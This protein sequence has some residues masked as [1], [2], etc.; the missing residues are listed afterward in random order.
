MCN[1]PLLAWTLESLAQAGVEQ[2]FLFSSD[3]ADAIR[4]YV[5]QTT[6]DKPYSTMSVTT[7]STNAASPGDVMREVDA[8]GILA[9]TEFLVVQAG[10]VGSIDLKD[11]VERFR[12]RRTKDPNLVLSAIV[13]SAL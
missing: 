12:A 4:N 5:S 13:S 8:L 6:F 11:Q 2:S 3:S 1:A 9:P 7:R 10:Y